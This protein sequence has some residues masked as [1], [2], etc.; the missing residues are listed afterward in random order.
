MTTTPIHPKLYELT[1]EAA[2][3]ARIVAAEFIASGKHYSRRD[4]TKFEKNEHGWSTTTSAGFFSSTRRDSPPNWDYMFGR[5]QGVFSA[6]SIGGIPAFEH[7]VAEVRRMALEDADFEQGISILSQS[8]ENLTKRG[9]QIE[10]EYIRFV[11]DVISRAEAIGASTDSDLREIYLALERARFAKVL[12]GDL[13]VPL[14]LTPFEF[15]GVFEVAPGVLIEPLTEEIQCARAPSISNSGK[16]SAF[17]IAA[18]T[19]AVV[20]K[21]VSIPNASWRDRRFRQQS[22]D[23]SKVDFVV[24]CLY[25]ASGHE[26]GYAQV[27]IRPTDWADDWQHDLPALFEA[28]T[29]HRYPDG[30][31]NGRWNTPQ[32]PI[33]NV[34]IDKLPR[35]Y[36]TLQTSPANIHLA[37][38]RAIRSVE[39]LDDEDRTIDATI[40]IEALLLGNN[41]KEEITH[42]MSQRAATALADSGWQPEAIVELLKKVYAHRSAIVHGRTKRKETIVFG[43]ETYL[44]QDIAQWLLRLLLESYL[45]SDTPWTPESLDSTLLRA[46]TRPTEPIK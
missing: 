37:A 2:K 35:L 5:E 19:H 1:L 41:D 28:G 7:A 18:A 9:E 27:L 14:A 16:V 15:D 21:D 39:R 45:M 23:M 4:V 13:V 24:Q 43:K 6:I 12:H 8:E 36:S 22:L 34:H 20:V 33:E 29:H 26:T 40:G 46:L 17:V 42:R 38:R 3:A 31:D 44:A 10:F 32:D 25:I 30:F 11:S